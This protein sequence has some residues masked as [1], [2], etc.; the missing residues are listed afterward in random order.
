MVA[1]IVM[2]VTLALGCV[3]FL[4][5]TAL[6]GVLNVTGSMTIMTKSIGWIVIAVVFV[7]FVIYVVFIKPN[8]RM[9][10]VER[11]AVVVAAITVVWILLFF[12]SDNVLILS[13][14]FEDWQILRANALE[15]A[16]LIGKLLIAFG[17]GCGFAIICNLFEYSKSKKSKSKNKETKDVKP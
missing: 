6:S 15:D 14:K 7:A 13:E 3:L 1:I 9:K 4:G 10:W 2:L 12:F 8:V 11:I 5:P 17:L 16:E